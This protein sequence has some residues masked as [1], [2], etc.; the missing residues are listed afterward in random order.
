MKKS[1]LNLFAILIF[2]IASIG[3][4]SC[5]NHDKDPN[6][7]ENSTNGLLSP[8]DPRAIDLGLSVNWARMN[9]GATSPEECGLFFAWGET[10]GYSL[11]T[12]DGRQFD[13]HNYKWMTGDKSSAY[14]I[15][16]Y[17]VEDNWTEG[18]WYDMNK[19]F[20]GDGKKVLEFVDDAAASNWAGLWRIPTIEECRELINNCTVEW[21]IQNGTHGCKLTSKKN[22]NAIFLPATGIRAING[23]TWDGT[24]VLWSSSIKETMAAYGFDASDGFGIGINSYSRNTGINIRAVLIK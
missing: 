22:G 10:E 5:G 8:S 7:N 11:N 20:I 1:Y 13:W 2:A 19:K 16:K 18:C 9:V 12:N 24:C 3:L 4:L 15:N 23:L 6:S 14:L 17:Q 21:T